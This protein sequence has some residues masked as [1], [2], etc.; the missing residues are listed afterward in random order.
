[1]IQRVSGDAARAMRWRLA[2]L[3]GVQGIYFLRLLILAKLLAPDAFGLLAIAMIAISVLMRVSD[4][5]MIPALVQRREITTMEQDA[6]WTVGLMRAGFV[7]LALVVA[8]PFIARL[9]NEAAAVAIIQ[10]LALRPLIDAGASIGVARLTRELRFRPLALIQL[11]GALADL[12]TAVATAPALGVWALVAGALAGSAVMAVASYVFAPHRPRINFAWKTVAP[13][14]HFGRWVL[15]AGM[16]TLA[17]TL[18]TQLAVSRALGATA[19][20][21]YFLALKVAFLPVDAAGAVVGSVA[22]PMFARM[23][24]DA[25]ATARSFA[26]LLSGL[27]LVLIPAYA[28]LIALAPLFEQAL[29]TRWLG[30]APII[31][32]L[33][34]A[35]VAA[36]LAD[37]LGP[38]L[39]GQGRAARV[40]LL[41]IVQAG[42]TIAL[43]W[44]ALALFQVEGAALACLA[45]NVAALLLAAVWTRRLLPGVLRALHRRLL[46]A[47]LAAAAAAGGATLSASPWSGMAALFAGAAGGAA[48][49]VAVLWL[50]NAKLA[51]ELGEFRA[52]LHQ[53]R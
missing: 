4:V 25:Q 7:A 39:L 49:A 30:T 40:F 29:G 3:A 1:M 31:R 2:Q 21:L 34:L 12:L 45:G 22:M 14:I 42:V 20:G 6:A 5:G 47:L 51:L 50:L 9:F 27:G 35:G 52:L 13:L 8:A 41:E 43:L 37:L 32:I 10:A 17:G 15:L 44:P 33:S 28:L 18:V 24:G 53:E 19:L 11:S 26:M 48:A 23:H 36:I 46:A 16:A 38:L